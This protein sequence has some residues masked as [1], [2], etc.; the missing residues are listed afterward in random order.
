MARF[1]DVEERVESPSERRVRYF[2]AV[3]FFLQTV[4][5]AIP[6]I[7]GPVEVEGKTV[8][9]TITAFN[10]LV[11]PAGYGE[12]G[13]IPLAVVGAILVIF[14]IVAFFF[15]VLDSKSKVKFIISG[16]CAVIC[17]VVI[18][19]SFASYISIGALI[20]LVLNVICLFMSAQGF[21]ATA[22]RMRNQQK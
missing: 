3:M 8:E 15:C 20:T 4:C 2:L 21:Q 22:M 17:A 5:T 7:Q 14:P 13:G 18:T 19:F 1:T 10:L 12:L 6:F 16:L 11:N 9:R